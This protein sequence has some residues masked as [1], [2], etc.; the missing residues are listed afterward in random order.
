MEI[1]IVDYSKMSAKEIE[2]MHSYQMQVYLDMVNSGKYSK[3]DIEMQKSRVDYIY[4]EL[5]KKYKK[6]SK[7][8]G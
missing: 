8:R 4:K 5:S 3:N 7:M 6:I 2:K 1:K